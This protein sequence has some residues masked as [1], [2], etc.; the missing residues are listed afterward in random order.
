MRS[1]AGTVSRSYEV[2]I[3]ENGWVGTCH[4]VEDSNASLK[5]GV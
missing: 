3:D 1:T 2:S 5:A 4:I